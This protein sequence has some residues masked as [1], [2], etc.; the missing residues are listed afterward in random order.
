MSDKSE[1][2]YQEIPDGF[3]YLWKA[4]GWRAVGVGHSANF[5]LMERVELHESVP[6]GED[7]RAA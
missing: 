3:V 2:A 6:R 4:D 7:D 1:G 5:T